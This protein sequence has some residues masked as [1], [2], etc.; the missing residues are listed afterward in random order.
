MLNI[1]IVIVIEVE[2]ALGIVAKNPQ[3]S[4]DL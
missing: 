1:E 4:E 2:T 3:R